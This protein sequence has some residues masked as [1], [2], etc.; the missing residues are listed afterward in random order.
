MGVVA[1]QISK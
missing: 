1:V